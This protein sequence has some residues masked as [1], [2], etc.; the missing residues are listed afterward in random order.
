MNNPSISIDRQFGSWAVFD[1][2]F[3]LVKPFTPYEDE[4]VALAEAKAWVKERT[5][6]EPEVVYPRIHSMKVQYHKP[7]RGK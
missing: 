1:N 3:D 2:G 5:D 7:R 4:A 6:Q